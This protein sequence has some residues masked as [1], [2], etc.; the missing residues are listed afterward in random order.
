MIGPFGVMGGYMQPQGHL[1][2]LLRVIDHGRDPQAALDT[3]RWQWT[4]D[5][6][7]EIVSNLEYEYDLRGNQTKKIEDGRTT[8]YYYYALSRLKTALLPSGIGL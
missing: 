5:R 1:Q 4:G 6:K 7:V 2:T 3:P 8:E